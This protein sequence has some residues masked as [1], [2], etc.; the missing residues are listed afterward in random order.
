MRLVIKKEFS[1]V[2][3]REILF[4]S[5]C[6]LFHSTQVYA[7]WDNFMSA[8]KASR[9]YFLYSGFLLNLTC[10]KHMHFIHATLNAHN[11]NTHI[12]IHTV[13]EENYSL[14]LRD[15]Y[16]FFTAI[17]FVHSYVSVWKCNCIINQQPLCL[18]HERIFY[19]FLEKNP[20]FC[21][22]LKYLLHT[23]RALNIW[24]KK[25]VDWH[26]LIMFVY[27]I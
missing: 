3:H 23:P 5:L 4:Y 27:C 8:F 11:K 15:C 17:S 18:I 16:E 10:T 21:I 20:N 13:S 22:L 19:F 9:K 24:S 7:E 12:H 2:K 26:T 6:F 1:L 25:D 14:A